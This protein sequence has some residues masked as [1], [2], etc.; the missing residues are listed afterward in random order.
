[1]EQVMQYLI[2]F[3]PAITSVIGIIAALIVGIKKIKDSNNKTLDEVKTSNA[4]ILALYVE[5]KEKREEVQR[6]N[7]ELKR[8][9]RKIMA[10][11]N[12]VHF[13]EE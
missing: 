10:K 1:M 7:S 2:E 9:L 11:L 12:H 6:E 8:D 4:K 3:S 13:E 5:E